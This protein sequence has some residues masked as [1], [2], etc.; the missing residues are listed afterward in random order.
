MAERFLFLADHHAER[1][2]WLLDAAA[3][4]KGAPARYVDALR[5]RF[6][7]VIFLVDAK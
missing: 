5:G 7:W 3:D 6:L 2:I 1:L 4:I